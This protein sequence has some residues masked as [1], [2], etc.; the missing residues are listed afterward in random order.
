MQA[1]FYV[2]ATALTLDIS[3]FIHKSPFNA[4]KHEYAQPNA[5]S[6]L[7]AVHRITKWIRCLVLHF[8]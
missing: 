2:S 3:V 8:S 7:N 4:F 1:T 5:E 6:I